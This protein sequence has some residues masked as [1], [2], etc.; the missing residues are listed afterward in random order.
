MSREERYQEL[1]LNYRE[2]LI[3]YANYLARDSYRAGDLVQETLFKAWKKF[4]NLRDS[5]ASKSWLFT[6]LRREFLSSVTVKAEIVDIDD[7]VSNV[8]VCDTLHHDREELIG[9]LH[10][11]DEQYSRPLVLQ[12][13]GG[14][15]CLEIGDRLSLKEKTV[16]TRIHR[17]KHQLR[18]LYAMQSLD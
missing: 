8:Y 16:R 17:A 9:Q 2:D 18:E 11:L 15:S 5:D 3:R 12:V 4:D 14:L 10:L 7:V 6:I 13:F 1:V